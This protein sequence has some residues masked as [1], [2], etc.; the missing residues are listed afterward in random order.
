[1]GYVARS[2]SRKSN[3]ASSSLSSPSSSRVY[4]YSVPKRLVVLMRRRNTLITLLLD[5]LGTRSKELEVTR[6]PLS[7][8]GDGTLLHLLDD[9][10]A[11][12]NG[13]LL[14][15][16]QRRHGHLGPQVL[17]GAA[18]LRRRRVLPGRNELAYMSNNE[19]WNRSGDEKKGKG[20]VYV[21]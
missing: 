1:M 4:R 18:D 8:L 19:C 9:R 13:L 12:S 3:A 20:R 16:G 11:L 17:E 7:Q 15:L 21:E 5:L 14:G 6:A 10:L 2:V